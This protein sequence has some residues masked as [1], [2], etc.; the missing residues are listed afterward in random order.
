MVRALRKKRTIIPPIHTPN[1]N[2]H[3][4]Q[5][6][7]EAFADRLELQTSLN[8]VNVDLDHV[9]NTVR[10]VRRQLRQ[11]AADNLQEWFQKWRIRVNANKSAA[12]LFSRR[13]TNPDDN[14]INMFNEPIPWKRCANYLGVVMDSRLNWQDNTT[15][16]INKARACARALYAMTN[17]RS[18][19]KMTNKLLHYRAIVRPILT[20]AAPIWGYAGENIINRLQTTQNIQLRIAANAPWFVRNTQIHR[21]LNTPTIKTPHKSNI[22]EILRQPRNTPQPQQQGGGKRL[23]RGGPH[24]VQKTEAEE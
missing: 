11:E 3:S 10:I 24:E 4:N 18:K 21:D 13:R 22:Q 16:T 12:V 2:V 5:E 9:E 20:Y 15:A 1:G 7:A 6:K 23:S 8:Y 17:R 19:L 14:N